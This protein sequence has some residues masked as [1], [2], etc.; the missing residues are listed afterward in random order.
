MTS[1]D[2]DAAEAGPSKE[3][4]SSR[5]RTPVPHQKII[6]VPKKKARSDVQS[7]PQ[8]ATP[9]R[10][11]STVSLVPPLQILDT[12]PRRQPHS[13][14]LDYSSTG[15]SI[16]TQQQQH[17][18]MDETIILQMQPVIEGISHPAPV[19][20]PP[21][22][23]TP[24]PPQDSPTT[25]VAQ[26]PDQVFWDSWATQQTNNQ[27]CLRRQTQI[28]SSLP[29]H[30]RRISRNISRQN[31]PTMRIANTMKIMRADNTHVMGNLQRIMEEQHRQQQSYINILE[32]NQ[33]TNES[34][35][36]ILENQNAA[37]REL[38]ATLTNLNETL[39]SQHQQ[40]PSSSSGT[41]TPIILPVYS[42]LRRS[43]RAC[44]HDSGK[45]KG[46]SKQPPKK[47]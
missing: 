32:N 14:H 31:E 43:T 36:R 44:Q 29:S 38:N 28:F 17:S 39:R 47:T 6:H 15:T 46:Q 23:N 34:I 5:R 7:L 33:M 12:P 20:T 13:P 30:L 8:Q 25:P 42:P 21:Q 35:T 26:G 16:P 3:V 19:S 2:D 24:P 11:L 9:P 40:Q 18:D 45:G 27:D 41:T 22:Q 37:T 10:R 1:D 4:L